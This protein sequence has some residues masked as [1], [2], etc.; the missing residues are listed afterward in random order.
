MFIKMSAIQILSVQTVTH[1]PIIKKII[2]AQ[3]KANLVKNGCLPG[4]KWKIGQIQKRENEG[5]IPTLRDPSPLLG[6][7]T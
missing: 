1:A 2:G 7:P 6:T 4:E 3:L 5:K